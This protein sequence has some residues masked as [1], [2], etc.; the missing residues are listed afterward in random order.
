MLADAVERPIVEVRHCF[1]EE[2]SMKFVRTHKVGK[3]Y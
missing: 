2:R 3:N 1:Q